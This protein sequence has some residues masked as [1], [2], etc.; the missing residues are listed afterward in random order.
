MSVVPSIDQQI[1][2][3]LDVR[4]GQDAQNMA[5]ILDRLALL[6]ASCWLIERNDAAIVCV[7]LQR[8]A[9]HQISSPSEDGCKLFESGLRRLSKIGFGDFASG[10]VETVCDMR[11]ARGVGNFDEAATVEDHAR[12]IWRETLRRSN[13]PRQIRRRASTV[14]DLVSALRDA[15]KFDAALKLLGREAEALKNLFRFNPSSLLWSALI[16]LARRARGRMASIDLAA[17]DHYC[18]AFAA[19]SAAAVSADAKSLSAAKP[20]LEEIARHI[21]NLDS[22]HPLGVL[23][24]AAPEDIAPST[25]SPTPEPQPMPFEVRALKEALENLEDQIAAGVL[26]ASPISRSLLS[27]GEQ[28]QRSQSQADEHLSQFASE[29]MQ[30]AEAIDLVASGGT[31]S[32]TEIEALN[33]SLQ[34]Y[35]RMPAALQRVDEALRALR[36]LRAQL[37]TKQT[38]EVEEDLKTLTALAEKISQHKH[39]Q[40][41]AHTRLFGYL[42]TRGELDYVLRD[43][44]QGH[45]EPWT[46]QSPATPINM[47]FPQTEPL[48][49]PRQVL[50]IDMEGS[51]L[52]LA[53]DQVQGPMWIELRHPA[54]TE[55]GFAMRIEDSDV[56][57]ITPQELLSHCR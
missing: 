24:A 21:A 30:L 13:V 3:I 22:E 43:P 9:A 53:C 20:A 29:F 6:E 17:L 40:P 33:A 7:E 25:Q 8:F 48:G 23:I 39:E 41:A 1:E 5:F 26:E 54:P 15:A 38:Q 55:H 36:G 32:D 18:R 28:V 35:L 10:L 31:P 47:F 52:S 56:C 57:V 14:A 45:I 27:L 46:P 16:E 19:A 51:R 50:N 2:H 34:D 37:V 42:V 12:A 44:G 4:V 49:A 11:S